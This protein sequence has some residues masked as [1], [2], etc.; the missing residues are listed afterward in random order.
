MV[1]GLTAEGGLGGQGRCVERGRTGRL[2][3]P[4]LEDGWV[5]YVAFLGRT[6]GHH[7]DSTL[8]LRHQKNARIPVIS[9]P[10]RL[11][12]PAT[13]CLP[14][15]GPWLFHPFLSLLLHLVYFKLSG[16]SPPRPYCI[17]TLLDIIWTGSD[18]RTYLRQ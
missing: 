3:C 1:A 16:S 18:R 11:S 7:S 6:A 14:L 10:T 17:L 9:F 12:I 15:Q 8:P 2:V 5:W 13:A 4:C